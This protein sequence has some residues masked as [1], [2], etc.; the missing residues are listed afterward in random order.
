MPKQNIKWN[1]SAFEDIRKSAEVKAA[2]QEVVDTILDD[3][4]TDTFVNGEEDL[5]KGAVS[6]GDTRSV[7]R[8][9]TAGTH[10]ERS[11]AKHNTLIKALGNAGEAL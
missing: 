5:Y 2:L 10:A 7:G 6:D 3:A 8:V 11:N 9:W 4:N 1:L